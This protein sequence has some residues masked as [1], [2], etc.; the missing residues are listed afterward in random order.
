MKK[1][2]YL[3]TVICAMSLMSC[4]EADSKAKETQ[5]NDQQKEKKSDSEKGDDIEL[6]S[7]ENSK[8]GFTILVPKKAKVIVDNEYG[9][10]TSLILPDKIN[11]LSISVNP[12]IGLPDSLE[13]YKK[14]LG[15]LMARNIVKGE[16]TD[17]GFLAVNERGK[18]IT[19][20]HTIGDK[21]AMVRAHKKN[22]NLAEK[23]AKSIK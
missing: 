12:D 11:E 13:D 4:G 16:K 14:D 22:Q 2:I 15:D 17:N 21:Q 10:T 6:V 8:I 18:S 5:Q 7:Y 20:Y 3:F 19:I 1:A 23:I 9:F